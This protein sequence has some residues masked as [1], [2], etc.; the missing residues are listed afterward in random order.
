[1]GIARYYYGVYYIRYK[2]SGEHS[3]YLRNW[4]PIFEL[5]LIISFVLQE[6]LLFLKDRVNF[7]KIFLKKLMTIY[8]CY[9]YLLKNLEHL[10][11]KV[12]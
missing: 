2:N 6:Y 1:M 8:S 3:F 12:D 10:V 9:L 7:E 4:D 11:L 5:D